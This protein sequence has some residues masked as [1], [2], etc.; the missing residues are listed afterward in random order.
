MAAEVAFKMTKARMKV[1]SVSV[2]APAYTPS[3]F[4]LSTFSKPGSSNLRRP[5][6]SNMS[7]LGS[8]GLALY[9]LQ[10][11]GS[12]VLLVRLCPLNLTCGLSGAH[13]IFTLS[14]CL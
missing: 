7:R 1:V 9:M 12:L 2:L 8:L 5:S 3:H 11:G 10:S 6:T 13:I 14:C 4:H